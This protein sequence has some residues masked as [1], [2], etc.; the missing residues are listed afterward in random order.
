MLVRTVV[1]AEV[2][3]AAMEIDGNCY[4]GSSCGGL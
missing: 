3:V 1:V 4:C 2:V